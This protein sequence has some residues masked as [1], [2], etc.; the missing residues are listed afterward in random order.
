[1]QAAVKL[2]EISLCSHWLTK[3]T[4]FLP[5]LSPLPSSYSLPSHRLSLRAISLSLSPPF[6]LHPSIADPAPAFHLFIP[7]DITQSKNVACV[8]KPG[9]ASWQ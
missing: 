5:H 4:P 2:M 9:K 3:P 7:C 1:M 6:S 8:Q